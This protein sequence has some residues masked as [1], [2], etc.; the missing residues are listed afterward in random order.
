MPRLLCK[1]KFL[2]LALKTN[3]K[4]DIKVFPFCLTLLYFFTF[5]KIF[6]KGLCVYVTIDFAKE[7]CGFDASS[8]IR[9]YGRNYMA[10]PLT[11]VPQHQNVNMEHLFQ[12][13]LFKWF[14][15]FVSI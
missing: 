4:R 11:A 15:E 6:C 5:L 13:P 9:S 2:E 7:R 10:A 8:E 1:N 3:A 12:P 14:R